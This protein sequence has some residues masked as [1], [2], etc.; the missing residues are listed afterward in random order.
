MKTMTTT[1]TLL[2]MGLTAGLTGCS[3]SGSGGTAP[4]VATPAAPTSPVATGGVQTA[5][6]YAIDND[7]VARSN[8]GANGTALVESA[9]EAS[10]TTQIAG[11]TVTS[12]LPL[13][14]SF[15]QAAP[16][17]DDA[18]GKD[19]AVRVHE[20]ETGDFQQGTLREETLFVVD[21]QYAQIASYELEEDF[22]ETR[23]ATMVGHVS[24]DTPRDVPTSGTATYRGVATGSYVQ[25]NQLPFSRVSSLTGTIQLDADFCAGTIGGRISDRNTGFEL[26]LENGTINGAEYNGEVGAITFVN[27]T[28]IDTTGSNDRAVFT[29]GFYGPGANEMAGLIDVTGTETQPGGGRAHLVGGFL[30]TKQ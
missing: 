1:A 28:V 4:A 27:Q 23:G 30:A 15:V 7:V 18:T 26:T 12:T 20:R 14:R 2:A 19:L 13:T 25:E 3:S 22:I 10:F 5:T 21:A 24:Q 16:S 11:T 9:T 17:P 29:G 8:A 6:G